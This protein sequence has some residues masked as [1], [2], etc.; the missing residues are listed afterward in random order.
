MGGV[1][2]LSSWHVYYASVCSKGIL[3]LA[4]GSPRIQSL[5]GR[6]VLVLSWMQGGSLRRKQTCLSLLSDV[7]STVCA[8]QMIC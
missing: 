5:Q 2:I 1:N 3:S 8:E 4:F 7:V 6:A